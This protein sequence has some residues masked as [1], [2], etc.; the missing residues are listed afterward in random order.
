ML[1]RNLIVVVY[2]IELREEIFRTIDSLFGVQDTT[3]LFVFSE[4]NVK[5]SDYIQKVLDNFE[6]CVDSEPGI[7]NAM[8][9]GVR[10]FNAHNFN[11][12]LFINGGDELYCEVYNRIVLSLKLC[13]IYSFR[14]YQKY[15][16]VLF[17]RPSLTATRS[18]EKAPHQGLVIR[19]ENNLPLF[20]ATQFSISADVEWQLKVSQVY[21]SVYMDDILSI[22]YLGGVSNTPSLQSC[23]KRTRSQ[24]YGRGAK[25]LAKLI[26]YIILGPM[27]YYRLLSSNW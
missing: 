12:L 2:K 23:W 22:M 3:I 25:E 21:E 15:E 1:Y 26:L 27:R 8:N 7:Y 16:D 6:I 14:T 17:E 20:E 24:G 13:G 11:S 10:F 4:P 5:I 9:V 19:S 18:I